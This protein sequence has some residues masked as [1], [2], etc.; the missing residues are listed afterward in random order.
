[1]KVLIPIFLILITAGCGN[2]NSKQ[3]IAKLEAENRQLKEEIKKLKEKAPKKAPAKSGSKNISYVSK[4]AQVRNGVIGYLG[5]NEGWFPPSDKWSDS[6][7]E[8]IG[9]EDELK[10]WLVKDKQTGLSIMYNSGLKGKHEFE[11][12]DNSVVFFLSKNGGWNKS[13]GAEE[14][15]TG[16]FGGN[17]KDT[18]VIAFLDGRTVAVKLTPENKKNLFSIKPWEGKTVEEQ[19]KEFKEY[20]AG[21]YVHRKDE[22]VYKWILKPDG[23]AEIYEDGKKIREDTWKILATGGTE[24]K[25]FEGI[26]KIEIHVVSK[27][28]GIRVGSIN[29]YGEMHV[30]AQI[31]MDGKRSNHPKE[32]QQTWRR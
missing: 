17:A 19:I 20:V 3:E 7:R 21:V 28:F 18:C 27:E 30:I 10:K 9:G 13:G 23:V 26:E 16:D 25:Q 15:H 12:S 6:L 5:D 31:D 11:I 32:N 14:A 22:D 2:Q 4:L 29:Q 24:F 1:M 8:Y